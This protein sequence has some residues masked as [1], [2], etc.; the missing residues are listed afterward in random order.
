MIS[1]HGCFPCDAYNKKQSP[2]H[3]SSSS[4]KQTDCWFHL[5]V[6]FHRTQKDLSMVREQNKGI[7]LFL[8][9]WGI[10]WKLSTGHSVT[11]TDNTQLSLYPEILKAVS[12][13]W[14]EAAC[15]AAADSK[16]KS[17][18]SRREELPASAKITSLTSDGLFP[19]SSSSSR[20]L[21]DSLTPCYVPSER[22]ERGG[23]R[24]QQLETK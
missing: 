13:K 9:I 11:K 21:I 24:G 7:K 17:D 12:G 19:H 10:L 18:T 23:A 15:L 2:A 6:I 1:Y 4:N 20:L 14:D 5:P 8:V 3:L 16:R 22:G